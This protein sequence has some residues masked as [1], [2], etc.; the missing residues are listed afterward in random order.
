MYTVRTE[1][2]LT[3]IVLTTMEEGGTPK[4]NDVNLH[5]NRGE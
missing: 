5:R 3:T 2:T 4:K 1:D